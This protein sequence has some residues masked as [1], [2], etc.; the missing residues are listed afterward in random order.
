LAADNTARALKFFL[1]GHIDAALAIRY[2]VQ[3]EAEVPGEGDIVQQLS[4][5]IRATC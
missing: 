3:S 2:V 5:L 4:Q 1:K